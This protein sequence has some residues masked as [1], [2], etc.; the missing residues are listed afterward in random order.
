M[1]IDTP[2]GNLNLKILI[3]NTTSSEHSKWIYNWVWYNIQS[4]KEQINRKLD[5]LTTM[6]HYIVYIWEELPILFQRIL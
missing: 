2:G 3:Y 1:A 6:P 5:Y 4:L